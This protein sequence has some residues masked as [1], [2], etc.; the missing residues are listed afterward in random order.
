MK[1]GLLIVLSGPSGTGKGTICQNLCRQLMGIYYSI[2][3]TTRP[4]R[5]GEKDG[6]NYYFITEREFEDLKEQGGLLEWARVYGN[7]Y[8]TPRYK[9][10]QRRSE[11]C[12]VILEIDIEGAKQVR[13]RCEDAVFL[14][15]LPPSMKELRTRIEGR[16]TE[17]PDIIK[18]R[19]STAYRE[20]KEIRHYDYMVINDDIQEAVDIIKAVIAAEKCRVSRNEEILNRLLEEGGIR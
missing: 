9:V 10:E 14:F 8:G 3:V 4:P 11:G 19:F 17:R 15:L 2:S 5:R 16:G 7:Y 12:D 1:K 13:E 6:V 20:L 18:E